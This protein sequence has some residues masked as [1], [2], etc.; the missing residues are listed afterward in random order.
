MKP[1]MHTHH[2]QGCLD[3]R[4][5]NVPTAHFRETVS[6]PACQRLARSGHLY[7]PPKPPGE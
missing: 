7:L 2:P 1:E 3:A 4:T 6:C 5:R